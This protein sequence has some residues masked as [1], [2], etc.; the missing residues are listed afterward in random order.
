ML[1]KQEFEEQWQLLVAKL[2]K[3][4][5]GGDKLQIDAILYL[6]GV[7]ELGKG[8]LDFT[9]D[10]KINLMHIAVCT[11]LEPYQYYKFTHR[12]DEGWPHY[13]LV[14][15]LPNLNADQQTEFIQSAIVNYFVK[16][17]LIE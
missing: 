2:S 17:G 14:K 15:K 3:Q 16:Q 13:E 6:I 8:N 10:D 7:Q 9:K 4:F 11:V 5:A 12:D 1:Q